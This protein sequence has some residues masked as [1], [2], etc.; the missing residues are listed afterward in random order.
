MNNELK[1][2]LKLCFAGLLTGVANGFF[3]GGGGMV[4]VPMLTFLLN[5]ETKRAHATALASILPVTAVSA[6]MYFFNGNLDYSIGIP[7]G[8]GVVLGGLAGAWILGKLTSKSITRFFAVVMLAAGI[9][10]LFF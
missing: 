6:A 10:L 2:K 4:L 9:K 5:L 7:S 8:A 1:N 3:G